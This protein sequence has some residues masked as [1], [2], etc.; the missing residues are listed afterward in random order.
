MDLEQLTAS[1]QLE[2]LAHGTQGHQGRG[3]A[4]LSPSPD[5]EGKGMQTE[6]LLR[7]ESAHKEVHP[8]PMIGADLSLSL[9]VPI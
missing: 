7:W 9:S 8:V 5:T 6:G 4:S 2:I 1:T 3:H